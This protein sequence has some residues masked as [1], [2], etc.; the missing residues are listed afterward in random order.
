MR[1]N[2][3]RLGAGPDLV[4]VHGWGMNNAV[5]DGFAERLA[6]VWRVHLIE[7]P[8]HGRSPSPPFAGLDAWA[9]ACLAVAPPRAAWAGWSLGGQLLP[10]IAARAPR[11]VSSL[12]GIAATPRFVAAGDWPSAMATE[13]LRGFMDRLESEPRETLRRFLALQV[14][15]GDDAR[16]V[17][18]RLKRGFAARPKPDTRA[19]ANGLSLL[20]EAD[21]RA[22]LAAFDGPV[23]WLLGGR[24]T[25]VPVAVAEALRALNPALQVEILPDAAHAPF[26]S[27]PDE[28]AAWLSADVR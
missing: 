20:R 26:L 10:R 21:T 12:H 25:L 15:G 19:L 27:H 9:D 24:D 1:L 14:R 18:R 6:T 7:L 17:L 28:V 13:S 3:E 16:A 11:A 22:D 5:W 8:G 23:R 2:V 4:L